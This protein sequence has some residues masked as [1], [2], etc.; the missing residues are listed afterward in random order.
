[1]LPFTLCIP[2]KI[3]FGPGVSCDISAH[4]D[5][6]GKHALLVSYGARPYLKT[7]LQQIVQQTHG[8]ILEYVLV[9]QHGPD[10]DRSAFV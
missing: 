3:V 7:L 8:E 9:G 5:G 6:M 2:T 10:H 4:I 1:M